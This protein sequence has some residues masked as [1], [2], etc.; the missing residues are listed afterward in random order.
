MSHSVRR[1]RQNEHLLLQRLLF[2]S[3]IGGT[4]ALFLAIAAFFLFQVRYNDS[5]YPGVQV[6]SQPLGGMDVVDATLVLTN[7]ISYPKLGEVII[8]GPNGERWS[9]P[10]ADLGLSFDPGGNQRGCLCLWPSGGSVP[11]SG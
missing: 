1:R 7:A 10:P 6:S 2:S 8:S 3:F 4:L 11:A 9:L 5:I